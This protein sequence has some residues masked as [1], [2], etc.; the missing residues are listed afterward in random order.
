MRKCYYTPLYYCVSRRFNL[1][2]TYWLILVPLANARLCLCIFTL[3]SIDKLF[4]WHHPQGWDRRALL[5]SCVWYNSLSKAIPEKLLEQNIHF[6]L[7]R[8]LVLG[9]KILYVAEC[10]MLHS[11]KNFDF[12]CRLDYTINSHA[13]DTVSHWEWQN[14]RVLCRHASVYHNL[15]RDQPELAGMLTT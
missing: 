6:A 5:V 2:H 13:R 10:T 3:L 15:C 12:C 1:Y 7:P 4:P 8:Q 11:K 9:T 14:N